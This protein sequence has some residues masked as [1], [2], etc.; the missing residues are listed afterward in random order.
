MPRPTAAAARLAAPLLALAL[1]ADGA[2]AQERVSVPE[3]HPGHLPGPAR[4]GAPRADTTGLRFRVSEGTA[5]AA[6]T[7]AAPAV[8]AAAGEA[9]RLLARLGPLD[10]WQAAAD[11]FAFPVQTR[12]RPRAGATVLAAFPSPEE[13]PRPGGPAGAPPLAVVRAAPEGEVAVGAEVTVTFSEPMVPLSTVTEVQARALPLR[14]RP[15]P[16][17]R[18]RWIDVR[19]LRFQ[20]EG[21]LPAATEYVVEIPAGTH[22]ATGAALPEAATLTFSTPPPR[23]VGGHPQH[24]PHG[25]DPVMVAAFDQRVDPAA[26]VR[27]IRL[28]VPGARLEA[29]L[30]TAAEVEADPAARALA[31]RLEPGRWVAFRA[32]RRL[33]Y[34]S[35]VTVTVGPGTPSA[36]GPRTTVDAQEWSFRTYG[37]LRVLGWE[38]APRGTCRPGMAWAAHFSN[39][40]D[41]AAWRDDL[42]T[43]SPALPGTTVHVAGDRLRVHGASDEETTYR[44]HLSPEVRDRFGQRLGSTPPGSIRV[45][46]AVA[47]LE[48]YPARM[49]VLDPAGPPRLHFRSSGLRQVRVRVHRVEPE[50]WDRFQRVGR[51]R[52]GGPAPLPGRLAFQRV[53]H[54][55]D[56][57]VDRARWTV[58]LEPALRGGPGQLVVAVESSG[59]TGESRDQYLWVQS[60]RIGVTALAD[61]ERLHLWATS[62]VDGAPLAGAEVSVPRGGRG[63]SGADGLVTAALPG[64]RAA[65]YAAVRLGDDLALL[66]GDWRATDRQRGIAWYAHTD[67]NLYRPGDT[68]RV[69]GWLRRFDRTPDGGST[70]VDHRGR[71]VRFQVNDRTGN[72]L[73]TASVPLTPLG[74]FDHTF[75]VPADASLGTAQVELVVEGGS[76]IG[77]HDGGMVTFEVQ[78]FRR[79]EY[80]VSVQADPGPH[81]VGGT[82][83]ATARATYFAGGGLPGA[84]VAWQ[85]VSRP[86]GYTPPGWDG[87]R[88]GGAGHGWWDGWWDPRRPHPETRHALTGE[89]DATGAHVLRLDFD[90]AVPGYAHA[91]TVNATVT[92]L[93]RQQW[94]SGSRLLVH[95]GAVYAGLRIERGWL[96]PGEPVEVD[97]AAVD[98]D[99]SPAAGSVVEVTGARETWRRTASGGERE[100]VDAGSCTVTM[101]GGAGRCVFHPEG[102]GVYRLTATVRDAEGR[103][104]VTRTSLWIAGGTADGPELERG[105][106]VH[107]MPD[108]E[109][110]APGDTAEVLVQ[111]PFHPARGVMT[112]QREGVRRTETFLA[113]EPSHVLRV[114]V[115][116]ADVPNFLVRVDLV[117]AAPAGRGG[118]E[119]GTRH[120]SGE[121]GIAVSRASR[122]LSVAALPADT[123]ALPDAATSVRVVVRDAAGR[124]VE[125]AEVAL[126]AVDEA[127]LALTGYR[128]SDPVPVFNPEWVARVHAAGLRA[129][130]V[131]APETEEPGFGGVEG[132]VTGEDGEPLAAATVEVRGTRLRTV[133]GADGR[134]AFPRVPAGVRTV[135]ASRLG[136]AAGEASVRVVADSTVAVHLSLAAAGLVLEGLMVTAAGI[137]G[138]VALEARTPPGAAVRLRGASTASE[139]A[140]SLRTDFDPLA[141]FAPAAITD[142]EGAAVVRFHLPSSLTRYRVMAVAVHGDRRAGLGESTITV[143]QPLQVRASPP[144][145]LN[146]G[147]RFD[148][149]VVVQN[150]TGAA[151]DVL[152]AVR[153][154]GVALPEPGRRVTVPA[155]DRV[156]VRFPAEAVRAGPAGFQVAVSSGAATDA[157]AF[158]IPVYTPATAEAFATYGSLTG[159]SATLPVDVPADVIPD[160]GALEV[161]TS[162]TALHELTDAFLYLVRYPYECAEQI[163][164]RVLAV[165]AMRDMLAAFRAEGLPP[166]EALAAGMAAD[167]RRLQG[168]QHRDGGWG[169]WRHE[170]SWPYVSIHVTHA[171]VRARDRG[172]EVPEEMLS[173]ALAHLERI[174]RHTPAWYP[175]RARTAV[176]AYAVYVRSLAGH[177]A[178]DDEVRRVL[179][180]VRPDT[181]PL[182]T[183]GWLL[184]AAAERPRLRAEAAELLRIVN[185]RATV[186]ASTATFAT[187]YEEGEYLLLHSD[188]RTDGVVLEALLR[189]QPDSELATR[190]VRGLLG[191]RARGRWSNTQENA[192][193]LLALDRYFR[194]YEGETPDLLA[195]VWL[196]DRYAGGHPFRGRSAERHHVAVPMRAVAGAGGT[197]LTIG[198]EGTGRLYY[199][200]GLR[201]APRDLELKPL[202]QGFAV[203]RT[204]EAVDDR[205]DVVRGDDGRWR[206]R[207]GARVRVTVTMTAPSRRLHVALVDPLPAGFEAVNPVLL[208]NAP[209]P[210]AE[211]SPFSPLAMGMRSWWW[212]WHDHQ[213]LRDDRAEAFTTL[214]RAGVHTFTYEARATTPGEFI[215]PPPRAEEM[216]APETFGRGATERVVV[217][218]P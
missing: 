18:W 121:T 166:P 126:V 7:P 32:V 150:Q 94:T 145:F 107:L 6:R 34:D 144:R 33:P 168:R 9:A 115:A 44:L 187:R 49:L 165:A 41:P 180:G 167:L 152:V 73:H 11:S 173:R 208:G 148:L 100:T 69:K 143:R 125:G 158:T 124:P 108:R 209:P 42:L 40:L 91:V 1:L 105:D 96:R 128:L 27:T 153:A 65:P 19:T 196:G 81:F 202:D 57:D 185:N 114:P 207:A 46:P 24:G 88:F 8:P 92:D 25:R 106:A 127:V 203:S 86:A 204:Y 218:S 112:V 62:L 98:V 201:Y 190:T 195:G 120:A 182:E 31:A 135:A 191:H 37:P 151:M 137:E 72:E 186:T 146:F 71:R 184:A 59:P 79:P 22:S 123:A 136:A 118:G 90:R 80:E 216:Y 197:T 215:V 213:N 155:H 74:G 93:N 138:G 77:N 38:C 60:T 109:T 217:W 133:T 193:V 43:V 113:T 171:L 99:G 212:R 157:A 101:S 50:D 178:A 154:D 147:D 169:F 28:V 35:P 82:A 194:L 13:R 97:V 54:P 162:S 200:A 122:T 139:P 20:P 132:R 116:E 39:P 26:V 84:A 134:F 68:V 102:S 58:D 211:R 131:L 175:D 179:A 199:R 119:R 85:A 129:S 214:L 2:A 141:V 161:T 95:P 12:P 163:A 111:L 47:T 160:F 21:R 172:Y 15:Q 55:E 156:E 192:W 23:T 36:E 110:Y 142:R 177:P 198:A 16:E 51:P 176:R 83:T 130:V 5:G 14:M 52:G 29:R 89:T 170:E 117:G 174:D 56:G 183:V 210:L 75:Q 45:G 104:A 17:G 188:R 181:L 63:E 64:G 61:P 159:G 149:P 48:G 76:R 3:L 206:V 67:R 103:E 53:V 189:A 140:I 10:A 66:P 70:L 4:P 87:W 30:A 164:S 205:D 78:E